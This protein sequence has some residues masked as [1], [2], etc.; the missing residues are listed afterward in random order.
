MND[1]IWAYLNLYSTLQKFSFKSGCTFWRGDTTLSQPQL[2]CSCKTLHSMTWTI[3]I[4]HGPFRYDMGHSDKHK[5]GKTCIKHKKSNK[6]LERRRFF[7]EYGSA[8]G[9]KA[10]EYRS[11]KASEAPRPIITRSWFYYKWTWHFFRVIVVFQYKE[12]KV[13]VM[14]Y[15]LG[16][17]INVISDNLKEKFNILVGKPEQ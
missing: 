17:K 10:R 13:R 1:V 14:E 6:S 4:W 12:R 16:K 9:I 2:S 15:D 7:T 11:D 5:C 3:L 8:S